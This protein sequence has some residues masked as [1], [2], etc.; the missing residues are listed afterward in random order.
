MVCQGPCGPQKTI[1]ESDLFVLFTTDKLRVWIERCNF[2]DYCTVCLY[3]GEGEEGWMGNISGAAPPLNSVSY[4][5]AVP[6]DV[7]PHPGRMSPRSPGACPLGAQA[8]VPLKPRRMSSR[9]PGIRGLSHKNVNRAVVWCGWWWLD[10]SN[11]YRIWASVTN[12]RVGRDT[13]QLA[14]GKGG[15]KG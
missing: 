10:G 8:H 15:A 7:P 14:P 1:H 5:A 12:G 4:S 6:A 9:G 3:R 13:V 11:R 2:R